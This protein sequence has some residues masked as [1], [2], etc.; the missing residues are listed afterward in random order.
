MTLTWAMT[1]VIATGAMCWSAFQPV[2]GL[3]EV[4]PGEDAR[5][6]SRDLMRRPMDLRMPTGF[7]RVYEFRSGPDGK[8]VKYVRING[9]LVAVFDRG[10]YV[11]TEMGGVPVI[12][13]GTRFLIGDP[14]RVLSAPAWTV[15]SGAVPMLLDA[16]GV[17]LSAALSAS[18]GVAAGVASGRF[19]ET[20]DRGVG[21]DDGSAG[22]VSSIWT[23]EGYRRGRVRGLLAG[24]WARSDG[25]GR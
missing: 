3:R 19:G 1:W 6:L 4:I 22:G 9:A 23:D 25:A 11:A 5:G 8:Q 24:A 2:T 16:R 10:E 17:D 15:E 20:G 7:E 14:L 12:P 21:A 18:P 13:A